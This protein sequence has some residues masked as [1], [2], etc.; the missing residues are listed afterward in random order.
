MHQEEGHRNMD[1][2]SHALYMSARAP[3]HPSCVVRNH[4]CTMPEVCWMPAMTTRRRTRTGPDATYTHDTNRFATGLSDTLPGIRSSPPEIPH[5]VSFQKYCLNVFRTRLLTRVPKRKLT[6][7]Y[8]KLTRPESMMQCCPH[9][10]QTHTHTHTHTHAHH[11]PHH[12]TARRITTYH[13]RKARNNLKTDGLL[14]I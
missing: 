2:T 13:A 11:A 10:H 1:A 3:P 12:T 5:S 8:T 9:P 6:R 7:T 4:T 14:K